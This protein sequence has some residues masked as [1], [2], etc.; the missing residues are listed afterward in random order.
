MQ[1]QFF[2]GFGAEL[3]RLTVSILRRHHFLSKVLVLGFLG[4]KKAL[5][6]IRKKVKQNLVLSR[7]Q[8]A[9]GFVSKA[10]KNSVFS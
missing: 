2:L 3:T 6:Q 4:K 10:Q 5:V 9:V 8:G 7:I 1:P